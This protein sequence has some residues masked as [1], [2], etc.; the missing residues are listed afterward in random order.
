MKAVALD[1]LRLQFPGYRKH[2]GNVRQI[3]MKCRCRNMPP[4]ATSGKCFR[5]KR[6]TDRAGGVC[7]GAKA[8]RRLKLLQVPLVDQAMLPQLRSAMHD[9]VSDGD[10]RRA[11]RVGKELPDAGNRFAWLGMATVSDQQCVIAQIP[12]VELAALL[13]D[14][15]SLAGQKQRSVP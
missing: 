15:F 11:A 4:A 6:M 7:S 10:G 14:R 9:P 1:A 8:M 5:A 12:R 2:A 3:G 13:A